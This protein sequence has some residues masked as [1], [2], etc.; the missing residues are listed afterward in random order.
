MNTRP[1]VPSDERKKRNKVNG[2]LSVDAISGKEY[3]IL[4]PN[5]KTED[6]TCYMALLCDDMAQEGYEKLSIFLD[7]NSTHKDKMKHQ[8]NRLLSA[9][10]LSEKIGLEFIHIPPYSPEFNL[11]EYLIHQL[12][13]KLL[14]HLP[15]GTTMADIEAEIEIYLQNHQLQTPQQ[16]QNTIHHI[17]NLTTQS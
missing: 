14:H 4:S 15:L 10:G 1:E 11:A 9:L 6:V 2:F 3:L 16:I 17:C 7:N 12:R 8:L 13:L 5:A